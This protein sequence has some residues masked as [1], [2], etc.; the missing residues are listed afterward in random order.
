[1]ILK[2]KNRIDEDVPPREHHIGW[3]IFL[4]LILL[5]LPI[6]M[7]TVQSD[8]LI[9]VIYS[10]IFMI[11]LLWS[12]YQ[13]IPDIFKI[14]KYMGWTFVLS[15]LIFIPDC[16]NL[17]TYSVQGQMALLPFIF[18]ILYLIFF[19]FN[20]KDQVMPHIGEGLTSLL[21]ISLW[22]WCYT[23]D[24]WTWENFWAHPFQLFISAYVLFSII[25]SLT[26]LKLNSFSC[27]ILSFGTAVIVI[28]LAI[29][30]I[31]GI[32]ESE[33][34]L[35]KHNYVEALS[36]VLQYFLLG[37]SALYLTM[38]IFLI[39]Q[40]LPNR[41]TRHYFKEVKAVYHDH[42]TRFSK[43]QMPFIPSLILLSLSILVYV[44]NHNYQYLPPTA[45]IWLV[46]FLTTLMMQHVP[47][48]QLTRQN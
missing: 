9:I 25:H 18:L 45:M 26:R 31:T 10:A 22:Y 7:S 34:F 32:L 42:L 3:L 46:I 21:A 33:H 35:I 38:N 43:Q 20:F 41:S 39:I 1:M 36:I 2:N 16:S 48:E 13:I 28:A 40:F 5:L 6:F 23:T 29:S 8:R 24:R 14:L 47:K 17:S 44:M 30:N 19:T 37:C 27:F 12:S 4:T 11:G 15:L